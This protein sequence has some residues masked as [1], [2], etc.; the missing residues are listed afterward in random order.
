MNICFI[1]SPYWENMNP[2]SDT[3]IRLIHEAAFRNHT[4]GII[5]PQ[6]LTIRHSI[7]HGFMKM[8][9]KNEKVSKSVSNFH[10]NVQFREQMLPLSGFDAIFIRSDPPIDITMLNFLDS[11][12]H[13][14]F[15]INS[16]DGLRIANNK[17]YTAAFYDPNKKFIPETH[18]SK[19]KEYL[20]KVIVESEKERM[21][22]KPLDGHGGRGVIILEKNAPENINSLLDFYIHMGEKSNYVIIQEYVEG[23]QEEGDVRILLLNGE[24]IGAMRRI[25]A[26]GDIRSNVH[27]GGTVA[28]H[29]LTSKEKEL[30]RE[31]GPKLVADGLYFVGLDVIKGKLIE[32]NVCSP[33]GITRI[34]K[35]N[36]WKLQSKVIDFVEDVISNQKEAIHRKQQS[37][38]A[39]ENA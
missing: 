21:I 36:K 16:V 17:V 15:I 10:K 7:V 18:V 23:A 8:I 39:V 6:N 22:L 38:K 9:V 33:G 3:T 30:C 25:P 5:Y 35:L 4:V 27:A 26:P 11:I 31:I 29:N 32:V 12:K 37:Q 24:P 2:K 20:K 13:D 28:R 1:V 19:N 34:N 14:T